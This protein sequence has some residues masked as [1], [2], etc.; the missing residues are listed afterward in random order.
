LKAIPER[1]GPQHEVAVTVVEASNIE[2][3]FEKGEVMG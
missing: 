3:G 1:C 2:G